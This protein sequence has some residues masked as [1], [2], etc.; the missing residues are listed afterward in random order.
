MRFLFVSEFLPKWNS[1]AEG[2][3]LSIGDALEKRGHRVDYLWKDLKPALLPHARVY[4][5]F[6]LPRRQLNRVRK[7]LQTNHYDV[8][9]LSQPYAYLVYEKLARLYPATLFLN[10]THGWEDRMAESWRQLAWRNPS[11]IQRPLVDLSARFMHRACE[12]TARSCHGLIAASELCARY[13]GNHYLTGSKS[14]GVIPYGIEPNLLR[15][16]TNE[17]S[18]RLLFVGQYLPRK[19]SKVLE[20]ALPTIAARYPMTTVTFVVPEAHI[21]DVES[22]FRPSFRERLDIVPWTTREKLA[23]IYSRHDI[24]L[25]PSF[26]EGFGKVF[27]EAMAAGLCVIGFREGGL[28]DVAQHSRDALLCETGDRHA[29]RIVTECALSDSSWVREIG[30]RARETAR[31][32]TW[33]RNAMETENFCDSLKFGLVKAP[34]GQLIGAA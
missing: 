13:I 5:L 25:F 24:L 6:E 11:G 14:I 20:M 15:P 18:K 3:L 1:G 26:F 12:R 17:S 22:A 27:L 10:R 4:E 16:Q 28:P 29:F 23:G 21:A 34:G 2:S 30:A 32:Y 19:G 8:V 9:I 33:E 31:R 7:A